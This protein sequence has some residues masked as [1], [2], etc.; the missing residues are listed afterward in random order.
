MKRMKIVS[1]ML[2]IVALAGAGVLVTGCGEKATSPNESGIRDLELSAFDPSMIVMGD[3]LVLDTK[4]I[5]QNFAADYAWWWYVNRDIWYRAHED[6]GDDVG[7][8]CKPWASD[9]VRDVTGFSLPST[10]AAPNDFYLNDGHVIKIVDGNVVGGGTIEYGIGRGNII[11]MH[12]TSKSYD[13]PHTAIFYRYGTYEGAEGMF[14]ID[15]NWW[16]HTFP[17]HVF[18]HFVS[19]DWF[20]RNVGTKYSIYQATNW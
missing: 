20:R 3:D 12:I 8:Q 15:S 7:V 6:I 16:K 1:L 2:T 18:V 11:Q 19:F 10:T 4:S 9:V 5:G 14:W 13:G 17:N